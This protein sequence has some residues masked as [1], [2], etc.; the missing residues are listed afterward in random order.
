MEEQPR[1]RQGR[2]RK[3]MGVPDAIEEGSDAP[4]NNDGDGQAG[5]VRD[6]APANPVRQGESWREFVAGV[7]AL[8]NRTRW[9]IR[10]VWHQDPQT[11][12]IYHQNGSILVNQGD[13]KALLN[14]GEVVEI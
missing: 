5:E 12:I 9:A 6:S 14:T 3:S 2:P 4:S 1:K 8:H 13:P 11:D 10:Q 7:E